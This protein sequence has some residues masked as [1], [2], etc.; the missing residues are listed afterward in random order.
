MA[1]LNK[2]SI[3]TKGSGKN[4][5]EETSKYQVYKIRQWNFLISLLFL[6]ISGNK[7]LHVEVTN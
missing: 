1:G 2:D 6:I 3:P 5:V 7:V 4:A